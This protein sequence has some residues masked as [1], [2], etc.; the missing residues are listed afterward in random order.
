MTPDYKAERKGG[1]FIGTGFNF[2]PCRKAGQYKLSAYCP[3]LLYA[4]FYPAGLKR[5]G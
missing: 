1:P 3:P 5:P 4:A 2:I